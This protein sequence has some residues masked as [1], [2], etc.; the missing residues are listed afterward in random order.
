MISRAPSFAS[1]ESDSRG[2][3]RPH[4]KQP[5]DLLLDLRRRRY[6]ASHGVGPPSIVLSGLEGTDAVTL[7]GP[8]IYSTCETRPAPSL[9]TTAS[10][11]GEEPRWE[12]PTRLLCQANASANPDHDRGGRAPGGRWCTRAAIGH[13]RAE[14][15]HRRSRCLVSG[16]Q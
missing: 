15:C 14:Q 6:G 1:S 11:D 5:V 4:G 13:A 10:D 2:F 8:A 16:G 9:R 12:R 7:T 3:S